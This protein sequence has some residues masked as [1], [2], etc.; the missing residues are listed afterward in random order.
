MSTR[1]GHSPRGG[2]QP[3]EPRDGKAGWKLLPVLG[4][5]TVPPIP[6]QKI[7]VMSRPI[8]QAKRSAIEEAGGADHGNLFDLLSRDLTQLPVPVD[9]NLLDQMPIGLAIYDTDGELVH[10]NSCFADVVGCR[11]LPSRS[12]QG[13]TRWEARSAFGERLPASAFPCHRAMLGETVVPGVDM[14]CRA[15]AGTDRHLTVSSA[16]IFD[17]ATGAILGI[18]LLF[19]SIQH[20]DSA[21]DSAD[22]PAWLFARFA[23]SSGDAIWIADAR[24]EKFEYRN[25]AHTRLFGDVGGEIGRLSDWLDRVPDHERL[26]VREHYDSVLAGNPVHTE[27]G[28]RGAQGRIVRIS[29]TSFP[30][31]DGMGAVSMIGGT[32]TASAASEQMPLYLVGM[33]LDSEADDTVRAFATCATHVRHFATLSALLDM[34]PCLAHGCV[35]VDTRSTAD[36]EAVLRR[37]LGTLPSYLPVVVIG[38]PDCT[39]S[40]AV[41]TMRDGAVDYL[42]PPL[43]QDA[44]DAALRAAAKRCPRPDYEPAA[45]RM[46][47]ERL[48]RL[49]KRE[50]E[51]LAGLG[52]GGTN[53]S[54]GRELG[55][56]PRTVEIHRAHLMERLD[57]RSLAE[58]LRFT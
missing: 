2:R 24:T 6:S 3:D 18:V 38:R 30:I 22:H 35:V 33:L 7:A 10:S 50:R 15:S 28:L 46:R 19:L 42:V 32:V 55:I 36:V 16:P 12:T 37:A 57:V 13:S 47:R 40:L 11:S 49:T 34:A 26:S 5:P 23:E 54:I 20:R 31:R 9:L 52:G 27:H 14:C 4:G 29:A 43:A 21:P 58:L 1:C 53:K 44:I 39:T 51:V 41:R 25:P 56:S 45:D 48:T 8:D 17:D